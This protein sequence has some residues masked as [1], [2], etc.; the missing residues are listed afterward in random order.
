ME[1]RE[2]KEICKEQIV[3]PA[4]K[5]DNYMIW[6]KYDTFLSWFDMTYKKNSETLKKIDYQ[7]KKNNIG[8][9]CGE[10]YRAS[11]INFSR[12][13]SISFCLWETDEIETEEGHVQ[14]NKAYSSKSNNENEYSNFGSQKVN[15]DNAG[16]IQIVNEESGITLYK[17]QE[18]AIENLN[19]KITKTSKLY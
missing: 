6:R 18:E 10:E 17:H 13:E 11:V 2:I 4:N 3:D 9:W 19:N 15:Y 16:T 1:L 12:G 8:V 14:S 7:L 5:S